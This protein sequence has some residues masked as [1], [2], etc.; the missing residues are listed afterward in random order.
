MPD[1]PVI[2]TF[3]VFVAL[4]NRVDVYPKFMTLEE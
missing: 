3:I 4:N 1:E 2:K